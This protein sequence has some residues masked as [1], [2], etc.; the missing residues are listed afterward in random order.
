LLVTLGIATWLSQCIGIGGIGLFNNEK[1][2]NFFLRNPA[3]LVVVSKAIIFYFMWN[4]SLF[5]RF[6]WYY[7]TR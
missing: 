2:H 4:N 6:S 5:S 3:S 1:L 7:T